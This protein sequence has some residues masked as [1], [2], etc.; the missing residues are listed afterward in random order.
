MKNITLAIY[1]LVSINLYAT[2]K[3][4]CEGL[5][6]SAIQ[7][8]YLENSCKFDK[9]LSSAIRKDFENKGCTKLF[10]DDDMKR[11]NSEVLG[12]SYKRMNEVGRESFCK[13]SKEGYLELTKKYN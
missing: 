8:F 7:N 11:L 4:T 9:H 12:S 5:F 6:R 10:N 3:T 13:K 1:L 2:D